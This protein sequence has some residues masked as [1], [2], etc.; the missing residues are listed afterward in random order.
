[1]NTDLEKVPT[2]VL[3][4]ATFAAQREA[5]D[6]A[7]NQEELDL[8]AR[9]IQSE[10][11]AVS[12]VYERERRHW[13]Y[14]EK[15]ASKEYRTSQAHQ[16]ATIV[17]KRVAIRFAAEMAARSTQGM[18]ELDP[19]EVLVLRVDEVFANEN[20]WHGADPAPSYRRLLSELVSHPGWN[21]NALFHRLIEVGALVKPI[22][23]DERPLA[24]FGGRWGTHDTAPDLELVVLRRDGSGFLEFRSGERRT[25]A[26]AAHPFRANPFLSASGD[27]AQARDPFFDFDYWLELDDW[28]AEKYRRNR[29][30]LVRVTDEIAAEQ[31]EPTHE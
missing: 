11:L 17:A 14:K 28:C 15:W 16:E 25:F 5:H 19:N 24:E 23:D 10:V 20:K 7:A 4:R 12:G 13:N 1:M 29:T 21:Q 2:E 3:L 30:E 6:A 26:E 31:E 9:L 18:T 27:V 8:L 22:Y